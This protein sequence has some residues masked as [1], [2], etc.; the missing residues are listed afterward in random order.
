MLLYLF[1]NPTLLCLL[2]IMM[3]DKLKL[4]E[5]GRRKHNCQD[6]ENQPLEAWF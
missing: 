2:D 6:I 5:A 3:E 1:P 4:F